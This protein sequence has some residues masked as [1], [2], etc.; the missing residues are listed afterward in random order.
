MAEFT[1]FD[2][3]LGI[4]GWLGKGKWGLERYLYILH[5]LTGLAIL[6]YFMMHIF[7]TSLRA[8]GIYLWTEG[9]FFHQPIFRIGEFLV[10]AAFAF[11]A[12]NGLRLV[13]VELGFAVGKPIEPIFPYETCISK[14]RPLLV[15]MMLLS[16][17]L[18]AMGGYE[19]IMA[20]GR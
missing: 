6:F 10:F 20:L 7:V 3:R 4:L 8:Y 9:N 5:R 12:F 14:Q 18:F 11:H 2:N 1:R 13:F 17:V 19:L 15:V 16:A